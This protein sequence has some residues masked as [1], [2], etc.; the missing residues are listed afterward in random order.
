MFG[1][2]RAGRAIDHA[3]VA[4]LALAT[5]VGPV[6]V[7]SLMVMLNDAVPTAAGEIRHM[8]TAPPEKSNKFILRATASTMHIAGPRKSL[9]QGSPFGILA[10]MPGGSPHDID[11]DA[12]VLGPDLVLRDAMHAVRLAG[13][14]AWPSSR[15]CTRLDGVRETCAQRAAER[16]ATVIQN[17]IVRCRIERSIVGPETGLCRAAR[18]D[19][20]AD[21]AINGLVRDMRLVQR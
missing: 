15:I 5:L 1:L 4:R 8:G 6:A 11:L 3:I 7:P 18:I 13:V 16:V 20:G 14:E 21:L 9:V 19:I 2:S 10:R 17:R 12:P